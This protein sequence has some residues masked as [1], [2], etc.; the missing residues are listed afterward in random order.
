[1]DL[2][3]KGL[4]ETSFLD[5]DGK[6]VSA[7]YVPG[8]NFRCPFCHN[9]GLVE[10]PQSYETIALEQIENFLLGHKDFI[11]GIC[12]TG[13]EPCLHKDRGL[14]EFMRR[15]KNDGFQVKLDT[16]GT[17]PDCLKRAIENKLIDYAAVDIKGPLDEK[18][19]RSSGVKT[20]LDKVKQSIKIIMESGIQYEFRTTIV[21]TLLETADIEAIAKY[22]AGAEKFVLQ[23]FVPENTWDNSLRKVKPYPREK[24]EEMVAA[25]KPHV[26][27]TIIR[28]A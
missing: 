18:Y 6:I 19:D 3:I 4:I 14:F 11:D 23:Q 16:N 21:P 26:T 28:G 13:G 1:M 8:C 15:I 20:D 2:E 22:I 27:N 12:L 7:L 25:A 24:L 5:W 10:S 17:D 9:S